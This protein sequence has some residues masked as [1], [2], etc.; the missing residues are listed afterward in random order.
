MLNGDQ[1]DLQSELS[2]TRWAGPVADLSHF[3]TTEYV[4]SDTLL[5]CTTAHGCTTT[6]AEL[7]DTHTS[8]AMLEAHHS[9]LV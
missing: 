4:G 5:E 8:L 1:I 9:L 2:G 3:L 6:V 7:M